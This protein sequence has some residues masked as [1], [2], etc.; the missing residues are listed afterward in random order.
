MAVSLIASPPLS[1]SLY[2]LSPSLSLPVLTSYQLS[3]LPHYLVPDALQGGQQHMQRQAPQAGHQRIIIITLSHY[4]VP[5][6]LQGGQQH[7]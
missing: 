3:T 4:L 6:A 5:D 7:V 1:V 2:S